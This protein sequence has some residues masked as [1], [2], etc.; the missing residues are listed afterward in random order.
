[1][2]LRTGAVFR[3]VGRYLA[4]R[5]VSQVWVFASCLARNSQRSHA[6][7]VKGKIRVAVK[8]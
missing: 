2:L 4:H 8:F 1:M 3:A 5:L 7:S 6:S